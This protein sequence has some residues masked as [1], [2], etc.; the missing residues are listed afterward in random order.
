[1]SR[2]LFV[3]LVVLLCVAIFLLM[4]W[5]WRARGKRDAALAVPGQDAQHP[6]AADGW[7]AEFNDVQYVATTPAGAPYERVLFD[8]LKYRGQARVLF[9]EAGVRIEVQGEQP[10]TLMPALLTGWGRAT[11]RVG[12][13][14]EKDGLTL[15]KW[16]VPASA[17]GAATASTSENARERELESA[18]RFTNPQE[19]QRFIAAVEQLLAVPSTK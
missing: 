19:A 14:V 12:K 6:V 1:M 17:A 11:S 18:F 5:G 9:G 7:A 4:W 8:G 16:R 10:V 2:P 13:T 3:L 15:L